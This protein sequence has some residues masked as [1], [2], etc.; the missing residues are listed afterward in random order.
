M[1]AREAWLGIVS[2]ANLE[3]LLELEHIGRRGIPPRGPGAPSLPFRRA[4]PLTTARRRRPS[5]RNGARRRAFL[6]GGARSAFLGR[7]LG[8][9]P[10]VQ[11]RGRRFWRR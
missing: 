8:A 4:G 3:D 9:P 11:R 7:F 1:K 5:S 2:I 10:A 6:G